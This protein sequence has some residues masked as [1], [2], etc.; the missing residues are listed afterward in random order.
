MIKLRGIYQVPQRRH[1][2]TRRRCRFL[3]LYAKWATAAL[4]PAQ[5]LFLSFFS[6][7][8]LSLL[9]YAWRESPEMP[10]LLR[11]RPRLMLQPSA[12]VFDSTLPTDGVMHTILNTK[13]DLGGW[14][15]SMTLHMFWIDKCTKCL[16]LDPLAYSH[17][18]TW[19]GRYEE[20]LCLGSDRILGRCLH[21]PRARPAISYRM[22]FKLV[23]NIL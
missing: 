21:C 2:V 10:L 23:I 17:W 19:V 6:S 13:L 8:S 9:F 18:P 7:L 1:I 22:A 11:A 3:A 15:C 16:R 14:Q 5:I 20:S 4:I 12:R